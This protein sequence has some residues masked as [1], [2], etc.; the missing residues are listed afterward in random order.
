MNVV[1][2]YAFLLLSPFSMEYCNLLLHF[3]VYFNLG[4]YT[5]NCTK[6][7]AAA[8]EILGLFYV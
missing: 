3:V 1:I 4:S 8:E 5:H 6:Q 2:W 7:F